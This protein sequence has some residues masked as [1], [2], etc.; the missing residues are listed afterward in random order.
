MIRPSKLMV[1]VLA[2][3]VL[4]RASTLAAPP[5][6]RA[7][8]PVGAAAGAMTPARVAQA[9]AERGAQEELRAA[10]LVTSQMAEWTPQGAPPEAAGSMAPFVSTTAPFAR[11]TALL[12]KTAA[13]RAQAELEVARPTPEWTVQWEPAEA[14]ESTV[15]WEA[16][17]LRREA[18]GSLSAPPAACR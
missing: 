14:A 2:V 6:D 11:W 10:R 8:K 17:D 9:Q 7:E 16:M 3:P 18:T 1:A 4:V 13:L 15:P 5:V 12:G